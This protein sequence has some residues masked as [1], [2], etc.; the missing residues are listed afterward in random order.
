MLSCTALSAIG[1]EACESIVITIVAQIAATSDPKLHEPIFYLPN[2]PLT[3]DSV[4]IALLLDVIETFIGYQH[5]I[6]NLSSLFL[7]V[8]ISA[9]HFFKD[10]L[11]YRGAIGYPTPDE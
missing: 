7:A 4:C 10:D 6:E 11:A 9:D 1:R 3:Q 2:A 8:V 5:E